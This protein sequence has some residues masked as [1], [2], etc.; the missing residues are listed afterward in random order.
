M[1]E[2]PGW[3]NAGW[4][5][6]RL[7]GKW[8]ATNCWLDPNGMKSPLNAVVDVNSDEP[9]TS[10]GQAL[11]YDLAVLKRISSYEDRFSCSVGIKASEV[12]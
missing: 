9:S 6:I 8:H 1:K 2:K 3:E 7:S 11:V 10:E 5:G 4:Y 12:G